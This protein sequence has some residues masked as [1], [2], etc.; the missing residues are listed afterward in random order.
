LDYIEN[1]GLYVRK[2]RNIGSRVAEHGIVEYHTGDALGPLRSDWLCAYQIGRKE[3]VGVEALF[4]ALCS[5]GLQT[6]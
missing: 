2:Q 6:L 3:K 1:N 5:L 4:G